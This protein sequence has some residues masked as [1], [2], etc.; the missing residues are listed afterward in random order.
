MTG[1]KFKAAAAQ[2]EERLYSLE[3]AIPL[4]QKVRYA[5]FDESV[6][7]ALRLGVNPKHAD[8]MFAAR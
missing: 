1:K 7:V 8:Q 4:V 6:E 5:G 3:E 2:I